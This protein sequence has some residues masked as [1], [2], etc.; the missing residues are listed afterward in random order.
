VG[1]FQH[2]LDN[3][4]AITFVGS[5]SAGPATVGGV[6]FPPQ[7]EGTN[8]AEIADLIAR[9]PEPAFEDGVP[10][11][12]MLL[13]GT[14]DVGR[15]DDLANAPARMG[16]LIDKLAANAPDALILVAQLIPLPQN[17]PGVS[18][19]NAALPAVVEDRAAAGVHVE[20]VDLHTGFPVDG[21]SDGVHP[22]DL[23]YA[24]MADVW[25]AA[26]APHL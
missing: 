13:A 9:V 23:G 7:H 11:V 14:N 2:A 5:W 21:L 8:G 19:Y 4:Y 26:L 17:E 22:N 12:V 16:L 1:L 24:F 6:P 3:G 18:D 20:L 25:Y 15:K 10:D